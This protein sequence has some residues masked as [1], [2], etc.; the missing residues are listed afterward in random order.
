MFS[1][2]AIGR[3]LRIP[4]KYMKNEMFDKDVFIDILIIYI[5]IYICA[6]YTYIDID[7]DIGID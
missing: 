5:Y 4:F 6:L 2:N 7:I 3:K 1:P